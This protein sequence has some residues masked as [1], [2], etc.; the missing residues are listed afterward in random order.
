MSES[1]DQENKLVIAETTE[2]QEDKVSVVL[3]LI[4]GVCQLIMKVVF[5]Y[6]EV[7]LFTKYSM[8]PKCQN[9]CLS[10]VFFENGVSSI[11]GH[12]YSTSRTLHILGNE[13]GFPSVISL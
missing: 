1:L 11:T 3:L 12:S 9:V 2:A 8:A 10:C 4:E 13:N 6:A 5:P 7:S